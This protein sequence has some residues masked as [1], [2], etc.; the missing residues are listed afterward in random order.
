[1]HYHI[2]HKGKDAEI[3][4]I[5]ELLQTNIIKKGNMKA[6]SNH[7]QGMVLTRSSFACMIKIM[8]YSDDFLQLV[9]SVAIAYGEM[10]GKSD[11]EKMDELS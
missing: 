2:I 6:R 4:R 10:D 3:D 11:T 1:M 7:E 8:N 5:I 9:D